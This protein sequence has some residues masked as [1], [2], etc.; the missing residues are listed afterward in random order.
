MALFAG[1]FIGTFTKR[2]CR[3]DKIIFYANNWSYYSLRK[4]ERN[5]HIGGDTRFSQ[6]WNH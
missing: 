6:K 2:D 5:Y 3:K 4:T 1:F